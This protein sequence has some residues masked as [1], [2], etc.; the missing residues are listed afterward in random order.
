MATTQT[1]TNPCMRRLFPF[2]PKMMQPSLDWILPLPKISP[3]TSD[4]DTETPN[5]PDDITIDLRGA[6]ASMKW[7]LKMYVD[8]Q[9]V[10]AI[11]SKSPVE[12]A[13][14]S[15]TVSFGIGV[16]CGDAIVGNIRCSG[17]M[18][19]T[20][21][22][23]T[24]NVAARLEANAKPGQILVSQAV[25]NIISPHV[26]STLI[27]PL[28]I[29]GKTKTAT[30]YEINQITSLPERSSR[31]RKEHLLE[32]TNNI[33]LDH[34]VKHHL[35]ITLEIILCELMKGIKIQLK[36]FFAHGVDHLPCYP[37]LHPYI[38]TLC[39]CPFVFGHFPHIF[40]YYYKI[41][42]GFFLGLIVLLLCLS[43]FSFLCS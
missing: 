43:L 16:N 23:D 31:S 18:D 24:V 26:V 42:C 25:M 10:D 29:K 21:I 17:R 32:R 9:V 40:Q 12:L 11:T 8:S 4:T 39:F 28:S 33:I 2:C 38:H 13:S 36:L 6:D 15:R 14:V 35:T 34:F 27:G 37:V 7:T 3:A 20:A 41:G 19:Y 5:Q 22:G 30:A 1:G